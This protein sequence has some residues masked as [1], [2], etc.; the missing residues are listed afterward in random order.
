MVYDNVEELCK[1]KGISINELEDRA[2]LG[3]AAIRKW[4]NVN[5]RIDSVIAVAKVLGVKPS[6]LID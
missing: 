1:K 4:K 3:H 2:G 5:P 6:K